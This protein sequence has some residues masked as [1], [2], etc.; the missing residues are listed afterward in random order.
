MSEEK[1]ID[2]RRSS[3]YF[4]S[5]LWLM[6]ISIPLMFIFPEFSYWEYA[7]YIHLYLLPPILV[8]KVGFPNSKF[9]QWLATSVIIYKF[10]QQ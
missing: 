3:I 5:V 4:F 2:A 9:A 1:V 10:K 7:A 6:F 8:F